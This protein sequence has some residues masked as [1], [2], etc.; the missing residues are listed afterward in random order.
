MPGRKPCRR[1]IR[2]IRFW[3]WL[4]VLVAVFGQWYLPRV[5]ARHLAAG[6]Q[7]LAPAGQVEV[8]LRAF[9]FT[10]L[11][12]GQVD[13][14]YLTA[15]GF[16]ADS[17]TLSQLTA[18]VNNARID[19]PRLRQD[20]QLVLLAVESARVDAR[21]TEQELNDSLLT[22]LP[23]MF[24]LN[25]QLHPGQATLAGK[26]RMDGGL[27]GFFAEG[28]IEPGE[29]NSMVLAVDR[30]WLEG[31]ELPLFLQEGVQSIFGRIEYPLGQTGLLSA[32]K[33]TGVEMGE[34]TL[35]IIFA[36]AI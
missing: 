1:L 33:V 26:L 28:R 31:V 4:L 27:L 20:N 19:L 2:L 15:T 22:R 21:V 10:K 36:A 18:E 14:L 30:V 7:S 9:P 25:L 5:Y 29:A 32:L 12:G 24:S 23:E 3:F 16:Q 17:L 35:D 13:Y 6:M 11:A 8:Q 34:G